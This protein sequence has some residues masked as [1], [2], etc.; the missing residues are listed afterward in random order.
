MR[1]DADLLRLIE[2]SRTGLEPGS[3]A[4]AGRLLDALVPHVADLPD[5]VLSSMVGAATHLAGWA[6]GLQARAAG[7]LVQR[8]EGFT[9]FEEATTTVSGELRETRRTAREVTVR[10]TA[11][12]RHP[13]VIDRLTA[14]HIDAP[15]A[16]ALLLAGRSLTDPQRAEAIEL[17]LPIAP[18]RSAAWL[19]NEM[20]KF[21]RTVNPTQESMT[22]V[23]SRAVFHDV[24]QDEMGV[25]TAF[26]PAVDSAAVWNVVDDLAHQMRRGDDSRTLPQ[27]RADVLTSIVTGRL[28]PE[29]R[30]LRSG[31]AEGSGSGDELG[32]TGRSGGASQPGSTAQSG[33]TGRSGSIGQPG[34]TAHATSR[35]APGSA[36]TVTDL[37]S[38]HP[39]SPT[40]ADT[41]YDLA[42]TH[43]RLDD[44]RARWPIV[45]LTPTRPVVRVT[46]PLDALHTHAH[47]EPAID[48]ATDGTTTRTGV[49]WLDGFGPLTTASAAQVAFDP[50]STWHRLVTDPV[51]GILTDY[52]THTYK[53]PRRLADAVRL[54]DA[55]CRA[56]GCQTDARW[57][58]LDHIA[59]YDT[60]LSPTPGQPGQTRAENLHVLCRTHHRL[61]TSY[62]WRVHRDPV[63]G[64]THWTAPTGRHYAKA[65]NITDPLSPEPTSTRRLVAALT[66]APS[67]SK[68]RDVEDPKTGP[69]K[70]GPASDGHGAAPES[71]DSPSGIR[72]HPSNE[73]PF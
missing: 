37:D 49:A 16:D 7:E 25:I 35:V 64:V 36:R 54:R 19:K 38:P 69:A 58:D 6:A 40:D 68:A 31:R 51:T 17:F 73:P 5:D 41:A 50:D 3:P 66:G 47:Q 61:K 48:A 71:P 13:V 42:V 4:T 12:L 43:E 11:G 8:S 24:C 33:S 32:G 1:N 46:V 44:E 14:G 29:N 65:A 2:L 34:S 30:D 62:G 56:P 23:R 39:G 21:A 57:C 72:Y 18:E 59:P 22:A 28:V 63:T 55:T 15:R 52:S 26:L 20:R 9:G 10:A 67:A 60:E 53:P 45:R 27:L 70:A